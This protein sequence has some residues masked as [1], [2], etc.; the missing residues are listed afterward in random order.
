MF[1]ARQTAIRFQ[2]VV[3]ALLIAASSATLAMAQSDASSG[4]QWRAAG[5]PRTSSSQS[6][7]QPADTQ[8]NGQPADND[9]AQ[10]A[11]GSNPLRKTST[12]Q[13]KP[14][15]KQP[16]SQQPAQSTPAREP[17]A[18]QA[19]TNARPLNASNASSAS[20]SAA[21]SYKKPMPP[22]QSAPAA[23]PAKP[24]HMATQ[25]Y[26][27]PRTM[28]N[29]GQTMNQRPA[30]QPGVWSMGKSESNQES[31]QEQESS[32]GD[33]WQTINV[34]FQG[35]PPKTQSTQPTQSKLKKSTPTESLPMPGFNDGMQ[36]PVFRGPTGPD[37]WNQPLYM[38][39]YG[40]PNMCCNDGSCP[41]GCGNNCGDDV[42]EPGCGCPCGAPCGEPG[43]ACEPGCGCPTDGHCKKEVFCIG[44]G[45][46]E[47]CHIV[48]IRWP[49]WQEVMVFGGVQGFKGPYD[50][51][52]DSGNFGF[53]E[54]F[55]IGA[56][57][58]YCDVGYQYG[59]RTAQNQLNGDEATDSEHQ[60]LQ[61]FVTAGLFHRPKEG[62]QFGLVWDALID[63]RDHAE[64]FHQIRSE[65][66][67]LGSGCHEIGFGATVGLNRKAFEDGNG[68]EFIFQASDQYVAFY[69]LHGPNGGEGRIYAG[70]NND[71]DGIV[72]SDMLL[73]VGDRF[74]VN[75]SFAYLI[76]NAKNGEEGASQEAW[77]ISLGLVW[78]WDRQARKSFSNCYRP[79]FDVANNGTLI[80]DRQDEKD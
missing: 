28:P 79:L 17:R 68:D 46:D 62:L 74:S 58:P 47:S 42:F 7:S 32:S 78:H 77:N 4:D 29:R 18:F 6:V 38:N 21:A 36:E 24:A 25:A 53:N 12:Q 35:N 60:F 19:P 72:G 20:Q 73:P 8:S 26:M 48:Q 56:K 15:F 55:N 67:V 16:Q 61:Q 66:S 76:P 44:P 11:D 80:V 41:N 43:C 71:S 75:A 59:Y 70:A 33:I 34:A 50:Q 10:N 65:L 57:V 14:V 31:K 30:G 49:K 64:R 45:D 52:R 23:A 69:R 5:S 13:T 27:P 40:D 3:A 1:E 51:D 63:E 54:G 39:Q 22:A 37:A 2:T 9:S